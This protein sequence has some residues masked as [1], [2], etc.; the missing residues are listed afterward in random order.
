MDE[1]LLVQQLVVHHRLYTEL[2]R[3]MN[4]MN[5]L[6]MGDRISIALP[7]QLVALAAQSPLLR[8][9]APSRPQP[10]PRP[11]GLTPDQLDLLPVTKY[12][13]GSGLSTCCS[14]CIEDFERGDQ[15]C[16][17]PCE[18]SFHKSCIFPWLSTNPTCPN[19]RFALAVE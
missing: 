15:V 8:M 9:A 10:P 16:L 19:C 3:I 6:G 1:L 12:T 14:V 4:G 7:P 11:V 18:H 17:L 2:V 5:A 13:S